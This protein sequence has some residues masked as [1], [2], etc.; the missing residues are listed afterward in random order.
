MEREGYIALRRKKLDQLRGKYNP[1]PMLC[2]V[3]PHDYVGMGFAEKLINM[4]DDGLVSIIELEDLEQGTDT[5][6]DFSD[7]VY[8]INSSVYQNATTPADEALRRLIADAI[9]PAPAADEAAP[10]QEA[11]EALESPVPADRV[12]MAKELPTLL[13]G[14]GSPYA[15]VLAR[16]GEAF[17]D[18]FA[19]GFGA[20]PDK[21]D[22]FSFPVNSDVYEHL[23]SKRRTLIINSAFCEL[24]ELAGRIPAMHL[25]HISSCCFAP[26]G[27]ETD[28]RYL[29][30]AFDRKVISPD[31]VKKIIKI[32]NN[33]P[34]NA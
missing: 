25:T 15:A 33:I 32:I 27:S 9:G 1:E 6:I 29:F 28:G 30:F 12:G 3:K 20:G 2:D 10:Q 19:P 17:I 8:E 23:I 22:V 14:I 21:G 4:E 11:P 16:E 13:D 24:T 26:L 7:G 34:V 31:N 18:V 5:V